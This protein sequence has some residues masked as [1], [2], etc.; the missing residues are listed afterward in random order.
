M[1]TWHIHLHDGHSPYLEN[2]EETLTDPFLADHHMVTDGENNHDHLDRVSALEI[3]G[4]HHHNHHDYGLHDTFH[5]Q[6]EWYLGGSST[7]GSFQV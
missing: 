1:F 4:T 3:Y 5:D 7:Q 6:S 2:D